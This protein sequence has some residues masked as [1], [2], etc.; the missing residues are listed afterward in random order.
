MFLFGRK[1]FKCF[2]FFSVSVFLFPLETDAADKKEKRRYEY[3]SKAPIVIVPQDYYGSVEVYMTSKGYMVLKKEKE[4]S[5]YE[6]IRS[7][8]NNEDDLNK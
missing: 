8:L 4:K 3:R 2:C 6:E 1:D 7:Y 5:S